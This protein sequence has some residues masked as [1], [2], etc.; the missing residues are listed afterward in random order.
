ME[1]PSNGLEKN[2]FETLFVREN[3]FDGGGSILRYR[4]EKDPVYKRGT[5]SQYVGKRGDQST[6]TR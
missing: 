2:Q 1:G 5:K 4:K 6:G 3:E